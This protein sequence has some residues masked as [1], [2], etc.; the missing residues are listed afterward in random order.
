LGEIKLNVI[1]AFINLK[2]QI[3]KKV[4]F[5]LIALISITLGNAQTKKKAPVKNAYE[6]LSP[7]DMVISRCGIYNS[8]SLL[9]TPF[10]LL[11]KVKEL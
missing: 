1:F 8:M 6:T 9:S 5:F 2:S 7:V 4:L 11:G 3:M 10:H